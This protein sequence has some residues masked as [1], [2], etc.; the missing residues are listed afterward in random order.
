MRNLIVVALVLALAAGLIFTTSACGGGGGTTT[1]VDP[2]TLFSGT[3][4]TAMFL[5]NEPLMQA[6]GFWGTWVADG[7]G[8]LTAAGA[9]TLNR[10][11]AIVGPIPSGPT[12]YTV[13]PSNVLRVQSAGMDLYQGGISGDGALAC[14][15]A[16]QTN[17]RPLIAIMGRK[18]GAHSNASLNGLYHLVAFFYNSGGNQHGGW[19]GT[20]TFNGA[21]MGS[22]MTTINLDGNVGIPVMNNATYMVAADGGVTG[23]FL[24]GQDLS[25]VILA[26]GE[27]V[28][29]GGSTTG[30]QPPMIVVMIKASAGNSNAS[31][32]GNYTLVVMQGDTSPPPMWSAAVAE[33]TAD[34]A[35][36]INIGTAIQN[37]D[38]TITSGPVGSSM[39]MVSPDGSF[40]GGNIAGAVSQSGR[41][42]VLTTGNTMG[43][44]PD[45][46]FFMRK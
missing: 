33:A 24:T 14:W 43:D 13:D 41:V 11:G 31:L 12:P 19:F 10:N 34:G 44:D 2:L 18:S 39:V 38:G 32:A 42:A 29:L 1:P 6:T 5:G 40:G 4:C 46:W 8:L 15:S 20:A 22:T 25:G 21:G 30:G 7:A 17:A 37:E 9:V 45:L 23:N 36:T 3:Y 35:G 26:G 16:I 28:I 27:L